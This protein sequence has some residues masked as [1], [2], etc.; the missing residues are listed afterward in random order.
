MRMDFDAGRDVMLGN[1][2]DADREPGRGVR[3]A[4]GWRSP[5]PASMRTRSSACASRCW[6]A[7]K[8]D[9]NDPDTVASL[10]WDRLAFQ[11]HPYGRPIKGTMASI[12]A[13][14]RDDLKDY[15]ARVFARDKLVISV[16][17][18]IDADTLGKALD[19]VFGDLPLHSSSR[20][21]P[22]PIRR[23]A[24]PARSSRWT[25]RNRWRSSAIA[26]SPA[27][28]TISSRPTCSTTSS[29][30]AASPRG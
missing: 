8:F 22:T 23:S 25:C 14:T 19:H 15:A 20:R 24:R 27:R 17:G 12:A 3:S 21:W 30:A 18:D 10:A 7:C 2:A 13:I 11:D 6:R 26:A 16:V 5:S 9:E 4:G 28:T 1:L 29:A